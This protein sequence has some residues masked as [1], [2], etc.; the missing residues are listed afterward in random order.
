MKRTR[1]PLSALQQTL[2]TEHVEFAKRIANVW[3]RRQPARRRDDIH[4]AAQLGLIIAA[5]NFDPARNR[6]F[7]SFAIYH[8]HGAIQNELR[9]FLPR[10]FRREHERADPIPATATINTTVDGTEVMFS[11]IICAHELP[12]GWEIE[13]DDEIDRLTKMLPDL[14]RDTL[15]LYL[16]NARFDNNIPRLAR[17]LGVSRQCVFHRIKNAIHTLRE[18]W[19]PQ[20]SLASTSTSN[21]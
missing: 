18:R 8:V 2:V 14:Q 10:G 11:D 12:I 21:A 3:C 13:S 17:H 1:P 4:S 20:C 7:S 15:H 19:A 6:A 16:R 5:T 9:G